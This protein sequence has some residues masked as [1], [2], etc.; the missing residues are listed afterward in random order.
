MPST[1]VNAAE[2]FKGPTKTVGNPMLR[3]IFA[4]DLSDYPRLAAGM[5][6]DRADQFSRRLGWAVDVDAVGEERDQYDAFNPLYVIWEGPRGEHHGSMRLMPTT[7]PTMINDHFSH[8]SRNGPVKSADIWECTRFCLTPG[9][10]TRVAATLILGGGEVLHGLG[11]RNYI[12]VFDSR[13]IRIYNAIGWSPVTIGTMGEGR[14]RICAGVWSYTETERY[15]VAAR[16]WVS[17]AAAQLWLRRANICNR[18][19]GAQKAA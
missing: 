9:A 1:P 3:Y 8:L 4:N 12:G 10:G 6:R 15:N 13:M 17:P 16:A 14:S 2:L 7:G 11:F 18:I 5:F 19:D